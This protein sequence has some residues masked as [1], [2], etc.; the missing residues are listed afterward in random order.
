MLQNPS[1]LFFNCLGSYFYSIV[2]YMGK[3]G[4][5][6][7]LLYYLCGYKII[8][9]R[10]ILDEVKEK[11]ADNPWG[12]QPVSIIDTKNQPIS[13]NNDFFTYLY[14]THNIIVK[15]IDM[16]GQEGLV[17]YII[18]NNGKYCFNICHVDEY[19]IVNSLKFYMKKHNRH[20]LLVKHADPQKRM[21]EIIDSEKNNTYTVMFEELSQAFYQSIFR[22]KAYYQVDCSAFEDKVDRQLILQTYFSTSPSCAYLLPFMEDMEEKLATGYGDSQY[23]YRGYH[24]T[25]LSK[26]IPMVQMRNHLF[27]DDKH[28]DAVKLT[29]DLSVEWRDLSNFMLYKINRNDYT[30]V[31]LR[32]KLDRIYV[33]ERE[34]EELLNSLL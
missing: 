10:L 27:A 7:A 25:V 26:I 24:Y 2:E 21:I 3:P 12:Y 20:Y 5:K 32:K 33:K 29:H 31:S 28:M 4:K 17:D 22:R 13:I 9:K 23:Y 15:K 14:N 30:F 18:R 1:I 19:Y 34:L 8:Y 6:H 16:V 11:Y